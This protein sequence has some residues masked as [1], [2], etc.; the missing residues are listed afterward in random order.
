MSE[1]V[2]K[3]RV[4]ETMGVSQASIAAM[5]V[6]MSTKQIACSWEKYKSQIH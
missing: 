3:I 6:N 4:T 2:Q 1:W 5:F